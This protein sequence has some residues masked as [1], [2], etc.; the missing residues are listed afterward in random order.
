MITSDTKTTRFL[1]ERGPFERE[2][3][4][5]YAT[6]PTDLSAEEAD[7]RGEAPVTDGE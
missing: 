1:D 7:I 2:L 3:D 4:H 6:C 5:Y